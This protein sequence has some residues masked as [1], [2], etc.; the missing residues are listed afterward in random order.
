M[1]TKQK[2]TTKTAKCIAVLLGM[3]LHEKLINYSFKNVTYIPLIDRS[4]GHDTADNELYLIIQ[5]PFAG[6]DPAIHELYNHSTY[7]ANCVETCFPVSI[8][9]WATWRFGDPTGLNKATCRV[10][11][12]FH[13]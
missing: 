3:A 2:S 12:D 4:A 1:C 9:T 5:L 8:P 11:D 6:H 7:L 10:F 13:F